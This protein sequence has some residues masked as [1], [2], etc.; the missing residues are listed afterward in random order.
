M[1][2]FYLAAAAYAA[3]AMLMWLAS[4][5]GLWTSPIN[6]PRW[7][8]HEMIF[9]YALA[10]VTGFLFTAVRNWT[11]QATPVGRPLAA[12]V[13]LWLAA[14]LLLPLSPML[15]AAADLAF[16]I[17]VIGGIARPLWKA[18]KARNFV[19]VAILAG[20][21]AANVLFHLAMAG[22][23]ELPVSRGLQLALDLILLLM[24]ILGGRVIP[25]FTANASGLP[26]R[27]NIWVERISIGLI[28][29]LLAEDL[30]G[31]NGIPLM[32]TAS[33]ACLAHATRWMLWRPHKSVGLPLLWILHAAYAWVI[34]HFALRAL[35]ASGLI[36][37]S[38]ATHALTVGALGALTLGMM[39]RT[40]RGHMGW[41]LVA[42][43]AEV[44]IYGLVLAAAVFRVLLPIAWPAT[45][46]FAIM[47]AGLSWT[48][49]FGLFVVRYWPILSGPARSG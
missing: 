45:Y 14:R 16:I 4:L 39:T 25:S 13:G 38:L 32:L 22:V 18:G 44:A 37:A 10:V 40:A 43:R 31:I 17:T 8:A 1:R 6:D 41:P 15:S 20:I 2:P 7:H 35:A 21:G 36:N 46:A 47:L 28:L 33:A 26:A 9:G 23:L 19:F 11:Q 3:L 29:L 12:I 48:L 5:T 34:V 30:F 24:A 49:A 27:P 42:G